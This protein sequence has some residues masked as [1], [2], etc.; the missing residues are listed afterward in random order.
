MKKRLNQ[1]I[2]KVLDNKHGRHGLMEILK[3]ERH[4]NDLKR[5]DVRFNEKKAARAVRIIENLKLHEDK[6]YDKPFILQPHQVFYYASILGWEM[7]D[8]ET[9]T[10]NRRFR[11]VYKSIARKN[12]KT[13]ENAALEIFMFRFDGVNGAQCFSA[14]NTRKQA[15]ICHDAAKEMLRLT[16][17]KSTT[18]KSQIRF[19]A[20]NVIYQNKRC[21]M[22]AMAADPKK[23]DGFNPSFASIDEFHEM[24]ST[25]IIKIFERG[26][27]MREEPL[28]SITTTAGFD[29]HKPCYKYQVM[30][31]QVLQ[32]IVNDD[33][34]FVDIYRMDDEDSEEDE[35]NWYK[36]NPMLGVT[37]PLTNFRNDFNSAKNEG[38]TSLLQFYVKNLNMW[39]NQ[40]KGWIPDSVILEN[41]HNEPVSSEEPCYIGV[42]LATVTDLAGF[43]VYYPPSDVSDKHRFRTTYYIPMD[44]IDKRS[45]ADGVPYREWA[46]KGLIKIIDSNVI[47]LEEIK[48]DIVEFYENNNVV[49]VGVDPWNGREFTNQLADYGMDIG[50]Y[51]Q[52]ISKMADPTMKMEKL[53]MKR[54]CDIGKDEIKRWN[55]KNVELD[56]K[57][58][59]Q[60]KPSKDRSTEK[61]DGVIMDIIALGVSMEHVEEKKSIYES[62][63]IRSV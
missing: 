37:I 58:S 26:M 46:D 55:Y 27:V 25:D 57:S 47:E 39:V 8:K 40:N 30:C 15:L 56:I 13:T 3:V 53:M 44:S 50:F 18:L 35:N 14:A 62:R 61:I 43:S 49:R 52:Y 59:G 45:K 51:S 17:E 2:K 24:K 21:K 54:S 22:E 60:Y 4:Q 11:R 48:R 20:Q 32:G 33:V 38:L 12:G 10:W 7:Y 34:L 28:L 9:K 1:Y 42:D 6:Y 19:M 41:Q 5:K 16:A 63:G 29:K 31:E 23:L 36:A